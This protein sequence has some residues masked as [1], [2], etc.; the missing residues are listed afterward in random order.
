MIGAEPEASGTADVAWDAGDRAEQARRDSIDRRELLENLHP[1]AWQNP[2]ATGRWNLVVI[3]AG[4]A[5]LVAARIAAALGARVALIERGLLGGDCLN[6]GCVPS[7]AIIR[8]SRVLADRRDSP[9]YGVAA[10]QSPGAAFARTMRRMRH[11]RA[12]ISREDAAAELARAGIDVFFGEARFVDE[13]AISV[14]GQTLRF[15]RAI[16][17]TG[18]RQQEPDIEGLAAAGFLTV[19][20]LFELERLPQ[21]LMVIGGGPLGTEL[22]Q[23]FCRLGSKVVL[24]HDQANFLPREERD[25]AQLLSDS[26]ARDGVE[27][28]LDTSA[29]RASERH[30]V[31]QVELLR[32]GNSHSLEID[33]VLTGIG[34]LPNVDELDLGRAGIDFDAVT[35]IEVDDHL[36]TTNCRV[37]AAGDVCC[38]DRFTHVAEASARLAVENALFVVR[39]RMSRLT[40]PR[41]TYTDPEIAHVGLHV[42]EANRLGIPIKTYTVLMHEVD[43]AIADSEEQG[44]V[45]IRVR[46]GGDRI[47]GATIV[48]RH[49]GEMIN[50]LSLAMVAGIGLGTI[51]RVIHAYPTQAEGIKKAAMAYACV[52]DPPWMTWLRRR[53][54]AR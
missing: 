3:G 5:G 21:R 40:I 28:H 4:P 27:I 46:E 39:K 22:G 6:I 53:W 32:S 13:S 10:P 31:R 43:R 44:F 20:K 49:A 18:G 33:E 51:A 16:V 37:F 12:R 35:G 23:A 47:L 19:H 24:V 52:T 14:D 2:D 1:S 30:S 48:A 38:D 17:A 41:C 15:H 7:K 11:L 29:V 50:D 26:L 45:K 54:F 25:A 42:E 36:R 34:R 9:R 8:T